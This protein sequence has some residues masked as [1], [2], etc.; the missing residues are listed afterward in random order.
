MEVT[1][2]TARRCSTFSTE[3]RK[4]AGLFLNL[5]IPT[6]LIDNCMEPA[7]SS[8]GLELELCEPR[9]TPSK[10]RRI[11]TD[12]DEMHPP[13]VEPA[14]NLK[15]APK[16]NPVYISPGEDSAQGDPI[17][18]TDPNTGEV[19]VIDSR[20]GN[21]VSQAEASIASQPEE[22]SGRRTLM[23]SLWSTLDTGNVPQWIQ[24][25]LM[26]SGRISGT[27]TYFGGPARSRRTYPCGEV[28]QRTLSALLRGGCRWREA[29]GVIA[30]RSVLLTH[31]EAKR[32]ASNESIQEEF[33]RWGF[34]FS[35]LV[36]LLSGYDPEAGADTATESGYTQ[37]EVQ[38]IP[39]M[40]ADKG[41]NLV[42]L[43][44][45]LLQGHE[46][47]D[48]IK[49]FLAQLNGGSSGA[50]PNDMHDSSQGDHAWLKALRWCPR[51]LVELVN[52]KAC[53]GKFG[54]LISTGLTI[55]S[56]FVGAL[57]SQVQSC[58][59]IH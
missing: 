34:E 22:P 17:T 13:I 54:Y 41:F 45:Q 53:R 14:Y 25:A 28:P 9:G 31:H 44:R 3:R 2:L 19:F 16:S 12:E 10:R 35:R 37:V 57:P 32:L 29:S 43:F 11:A 46:L 50:T 26:H 4:E 7:K 21:S 48:L 58:S 27:S 42:I 6:R 51:E 18:W 24:K 59:M 38:S 56:E 33:R 52:S 39:D 5:I 47:R 49:A 8:V 1:S 23:A 36:G 30:D 55:D 20:T 15:V 40:V